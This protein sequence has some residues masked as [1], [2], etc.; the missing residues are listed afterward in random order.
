MFGYVKV[1]S[2]ELKVKEYELYRGTYCGLCR[3]MGKCTGQCSR[4]T[5]SYDFVFLALVRIVLEEREE[6]VRFQQKRCLA[7]P[8]KKRNSMVRNG[9]LDY[10]A[11]AAALLN[12]HKLADDISDEKG[13]KKAVAVLAKPFVS[14]GRKRSFKNGFE[15]LDQKV[16][17]GLSRLSQLEKQESASV[18][19]PAELFGSILG[20]IM[21][22]GLDG[23][24]ARIAYRLGFEVGAWIYIADA[25]DDMRSDLEKGRYNP[26]LKLYGGV[27]PNADQLESISIAIKNRLYGATDALDL[28]DFKDESIKNL[29]VN[30][31]C[32]GM[33]EKIEDIIEKYKT[34]SKVIDKET[35]K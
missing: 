35:S 6:E 10:S 21:S 33:P 28:M 22:F 29:L 7:H 19:E 26:I 4:M 5:L 30:L 8:I 14:G 9:A 3:A 20:D 25:L 31:L 15:A 13:L 12:F 1:N 18:D 11:Y 23:P 2:S 34:P 24:S 27:I 16:R 32:L 17:E